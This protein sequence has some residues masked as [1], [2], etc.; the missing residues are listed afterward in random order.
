[1]HMEKNDNSED[2]HSP[3]DMEIDRLPLFSLVTIG[4]KS[5]P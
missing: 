5:D 1:M 3:R 4:V 2:L